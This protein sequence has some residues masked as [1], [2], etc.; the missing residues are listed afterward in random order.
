MGNLSQEDINRM[1]ADGRSEQEIA[2]FN[3]EKQKDYEPLLRDPETP[4]K[5][6]RDIVDRITLVPLKVLALRHPNIGASQIKYILEKADKKKYQKELIKAFLEGPGMSLTDFENLLNHYNQA[7]RL[8]G[9]ILELIWA[10]EVDISEKNLESYLG[11]FTLSS[12][13][14]KVVGKL[15]N[16]KRATDKMVMTVYNSPR[17]SSVSDEIFF[18]AFKEYHDFENIRI[19][20]YEVEQSEI[21]IS[22][23]AKNMFLF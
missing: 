7:N 22:D 8:T 11:T 13:N 3:A 9:F 15:L 14:A 10:D 12:G 16:S 2:Y 5:I 23:E 1:R 19:D 17:N 4:P 21:W 18:E 20:L 6:I